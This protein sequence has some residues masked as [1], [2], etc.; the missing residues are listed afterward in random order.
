MSNF[1]FNDP[2]ELPEDFGSGDTESENSEPD[3]AMIHL[4]DQEQAAFANEVAPV[5]EAI[6]GFKHECHCAEDY[7]NGNV[8]EITKCFYDL[9]LDAMETC[10]KL[11]ADNDQLKAISQSLI[12]ALKATQKELGIDSESKPS[13]IENP[14]GD[15]EKLQDRDAAGNN[16]NGT[17]ES[18]WENEGGNTVTDDS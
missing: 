7:A 17:L 3:P 16:T 9:A 11:K 5:F 6:Y 8:G 13:N 10:A 14:D 4:M 15:S 12:M 1:P 2:S 18:A